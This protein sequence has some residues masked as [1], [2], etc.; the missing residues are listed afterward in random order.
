M[1]HNHNCE[2]LLAAV[3]NLMTV[4]IRGVCTKK[5]AVFS[6]AQEL[7]FSNQYSVVTGIA[8]SDNKLAQLFDVQSGFFQ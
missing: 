4:L 8:N 3:N 6:P 1:L 5:F 7:H 2:Y